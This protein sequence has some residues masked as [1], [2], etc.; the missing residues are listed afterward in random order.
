MATAATIALTGGWAAAADLPTK[1]PLSVAAGCDAAKF[2]GGYLGVSGGGV[3][4]TA[5]RTDQ[6]AFINT[7]AS[8]VQKK[9]GGIVGGQIGYNW[10]TCR[11]LW[12][13][14]IDGSWAG[15]KAT[16]HF[17]HN[18]DGGNEP[19]VPGAEFINSRLGALVTGRIRSGL[20]LD[21]LLLYV[22]GGFAAARIKTT[23]AD[24][25]PSDNQPFGEQVTLQE[26]RWV[27]SLVLAPSGPGRITGASNQ[28]CSMWMCL[29][30]LTMWSSRILG[31]PTSSTAIRH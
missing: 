26:W 5:N 19:G 8:Y 3:N 15:A 11:A 23:W 1:A 24:L 2:Q 9:S 10:T 6:D 25:S 14:E 16:T 7:E 12:G 28:R 29:I 20:V 13:I 27:G 22:T 18:R 31:A 21:N 4:Y 30:A 17:D